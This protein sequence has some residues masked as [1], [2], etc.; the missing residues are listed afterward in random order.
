MSRKSSILACWG[1]LIFAVNSVLAIDSELQIPSKW[2]RQDSIILDGKVIQVHSAVSFDS[3]PERT[4]TKNSLRIATAVELNRALGTGGRGEDDQWRKWTGEFDRAWMVQVAFSPSRSSLN[5]INGS[6]RWLP[7]IALGVS[8]WSIQN[9][10]LESLPDSLIGFIPH[11]SLSP[12]QGVVYERFPIG[13]E[14]DTLTIPIARQES[15]SPHVML[16]LNMHSNAWSGAI[17]LGFSRI[18]PHTERILLRAPSL[19]E[20]PF[21]VGEVV[22]GVWRPRMEFVVGYQ[23][24]QSPMS[25]RFNVQKILGY[26]QDQWIGVGFRYQF[27]EP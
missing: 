11:S 7:S 24:I 15:I 5:R 23:F 8:R 27:I 13:V 9:V 16:G 22:D 1:A 2:V 18:S 17:S 14:T 26:Q 25:I 3:I 20:E 19:T 10:N 6:A 4:R 12:L 21:N